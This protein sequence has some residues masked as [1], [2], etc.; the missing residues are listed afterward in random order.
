MNKSGIKLDNTTQALETK[1]NLPADVRYCKKCVM[2][3]QRPATHPE[4]TKRTSGDTPISAFGEDGICDACR[5]YETKQHIDWDARGKELEAICHK[6]RK[7]DGSYDV[8]VPGSGG[9]DSIFVSHMLK[10]KYGLNPLIVTWAPHSY[11]D[12]GRY[13]LEAWQKCGHDHVL[14]TPNPVVHAKLTKLAFTNLVNPFQPFIIGQKICGI[15][16]AKKFGIE[17]VMYGENQAEAHNDLEKTKTPLMDPVHYT[18]NSYDEPMYIGGVELRDLEKHGIGMCDLQSYLPLLR[19]EVDKSGLEVHFMSYYTNWSPQ[20]SYYYVKDCSG[21]KSNP[22]GRSE[23]TY[24]K[25]S[26]LDDKIDGQHYFTSLIK[27]GQG[28][29][30][31]DACRDIRDGIITREE[32]V[33]L[34]KKFDQEKPSNHFQFFLDYIGVSEEEYWEVINEARSPHLWKF[35]D[36]EWQ[37]RHPCR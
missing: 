31:N 6:Y 15:Q 27:F 1:H 37:L 33:Q 34:V 4:L 17:F 18:C 22:T 32:G 28:R 12:I 26:S 13:N 19:E 35:E 23:G 7:N 16:M 20:R 9:K 21:F 3:N 11:T 29:A 5:Y 10:E 14:F 30:M 8:I 25:F 24:T 2:S 36:G